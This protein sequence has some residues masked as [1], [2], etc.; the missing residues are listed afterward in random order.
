MI[1]PRGKEHIYQNNERPKRHVY[2]VMWTQM[3]SRVRV[4]YDRVFDYKSQQPGIIEVI[5]EYPE[6]WTHDFFIAWLEK[7]LKNG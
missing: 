3:C 2:V 4:L 5:L 7:R 1:E 6:E